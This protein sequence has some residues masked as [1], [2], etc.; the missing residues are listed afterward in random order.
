MYVPNPLITTET[1]PFY[2][3]GTF[4]SAEIVT[5]RVIN[6]VE[7]GVLAFGPAKWAF[8]S[9]QQNNTYCIPTRIWGVKWTI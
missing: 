9:V 1:R 3:S 7:N 8:T 6:S 5:Y 4:A 2:L